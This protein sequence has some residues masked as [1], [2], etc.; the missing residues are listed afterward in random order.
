M[1]RSYVAMIMTFMLC[2]PTSQVFAQGAGIEWKTLIQEVVELYRAGQ[3]G[4]AVM[5]AQAALQVAE[6]N[7]GS[8][9]P[10]V[11]TSLNSLANLYYTQGNYTKAEPLYKR[12]L[13]I[14]EKALGPNHPDVAT[15]LESLALLYRAT[16]R[17]AEAKKL[18]GRAKNIRAI[19]R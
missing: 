4:R 11:A 6:K 10:D 16:N 17:S 1:K 9:H 12:S 18:E 19:K 14:L 5:V 2:L 3:Y 13:D 15:N 7:V 8:N